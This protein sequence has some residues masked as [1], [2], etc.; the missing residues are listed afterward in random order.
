MSRR[1]VSTFLAALLTALMVGMRDSTGLAPPP[2]L[3]I[4]EEV[5]WLSPEL[6]D[7]LDGMI[8]FEESPEPDEV[9]YEP[10]AASAAGRGPLRAVRA[11]LARMMRRGD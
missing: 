1:S 10:P 8:T 11:L 3:F 2:P 5:H 4:T 7:E 6:D 9:K